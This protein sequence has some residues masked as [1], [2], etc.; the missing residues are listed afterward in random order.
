MK[1]HLLPVL[2]CPDC[3]G[4]LA[5]RKLKLQ[6]R[7]NEEI[8]EGELYCAK[9]RQVFPIVDSI[10]RLY[11]SGELDARVVRTRESFGWEWLRYPGS[12]EADLGIFLEE[13]QTGGED[14]EGRFVLD[15]G[16][17]MGRYAKVA[18]SLGAQ[19]VAFDLSDS[20]LRLIPHARENAGLHL[21]QGNL[22]KPPFKKGVF[23]IVYSQGVI[24]HTSDTRLAFDRIAPL[25][26]PGGRLSV[27]VYG[28]PGSYASFSTNPL[29]ASRT[30]LKSLLPPVWLAVWCR[31]ILSD[32]L[33]AFT[34]RMPVWLL[35]AL[36]YPLTVLGAIPFLKY[37]TFSVEPE[38]KV[39]LIENFDWLAPPF[40]SKHTKEEVGAWFEEAGFSVVKRLPHGV[41]P[42]IGILGIKKADGGP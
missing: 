10:P 22:H 28:T 5:Y 30:A 26:K 4:D 21:V 1:L 32:A 6:P 24:H 23:D 25:V 42:K 13:T 33:R 14:W 3:G 7:E 9:C 2:A 8:E 19:V 15:A 31:Q 35:Y 40:Q 29:R 27:W 41:V 20:I 36:C 37:L 38:F 17:G 18:L 11:P 39:R 12:R 34:T 16:C